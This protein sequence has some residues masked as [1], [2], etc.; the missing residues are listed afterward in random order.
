[1]AR[2]SQRHVP[3]ALFVLAAALIAARVAVTFLPAAKE[4]HGLVQW[5]PVEQARARA[6]TSG[7]PILYDFTAA[8]CR[9]CRLLEEQVFNDRRLAGT[10]NQRFV[11]VR[12]VDRQREDGANPAVV[13]N[14]Q[15]D[16]GVRAFPTLVFAD[17]QGQPLQKMEG[18]SGAEE[19]ERVMDTVR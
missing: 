2:T 1:M 17:A 3:I 18:F 8:W 11:P 16:Y 15:R 5:V 19:F 13:E 9:P 6:A 4:A 14:L 10:I 12:V 7:K